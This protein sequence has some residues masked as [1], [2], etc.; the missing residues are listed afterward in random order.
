M[1]ESAVSPSDEQKPVMLLAVLGQHIRE[2]REERGWS[3]EQLGKRAGGLNKE[4]VNRVELGRDTRVSTLTKLG[5]ALNTPLGI[6]IAGD[7]GD[8]LLLEVPRPP[9]DQA[10]GLR[11]LTWHTAGDTPPSGI[12]LSDDGVL[13]ARLYQRADTQMRAIVR[14]ALGVSDR[15]TTTAEERPAADHQTEIAQT[16][17]AG[18]HSGDVDLGQLPGGDRVLL[19]H[20]VSHA[21][22]N[23]ADARTSLEK[24]LADLAAVAERLPRGQTAVARGGGTGSPARDRQRRQSHDRK[25]AKKSPRRRQGK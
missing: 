1:A 14:V 12:G 20:D 8:R 3:Q 22:P 7:V 25:T 15:P 10:G 16:E 4:T 11:F 2:L 18:A 24:I 13:I 6:Y 9:S 19:T 21:D 5:L 23:L 17:P